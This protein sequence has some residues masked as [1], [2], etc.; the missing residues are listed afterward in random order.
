MATPQIPEGKCVH[1]Q[2]P[3]LDLFAEWTD[4]YQTPQGKRAILSGEIVFDCDYCEGRLQLT[5]PLALLHPRKG[6]DESRLAKRKRLRCEDW[7]RSQHPGESL[8][9]VVEKAGWQFG[10]KWAFE[11]YNWGEGEV[12]RHGADAPPASQGANP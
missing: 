6:P 12:H 9:Q 1:C 4:E 2:A 8:S 10:G 5:L 7:L 11:G 3:I